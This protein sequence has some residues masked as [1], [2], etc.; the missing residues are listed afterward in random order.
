MGLRKEAFCLIM[1][2]MGFLP[3]ALLNDLIYN[4]TRV[5]FSPLLLESLA[6]ALFR[7]SC[8]SLGIGPYPASV[9]SCFHSSVWWLGLLYSYSMSHPLS[10]WTLSV[11]LIP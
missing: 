6:L 9:A 1:N 5:S 11:V 7:L 2:S 10:G 3:G 4:D 8:F